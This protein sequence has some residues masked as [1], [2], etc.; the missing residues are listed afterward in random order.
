MEVYYTGWLSHGKEF[1][2]SVKLNKPFIFELGERQLKV[3]LQLDYGAV[4]SLP[5][6]P[7][8]AS[9]FFGGIA[10][11]SMRRRESN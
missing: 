10:G 9:L 7:K 6:V 1:D 11:D 4:D 3:P 8:D 2:S 5:E